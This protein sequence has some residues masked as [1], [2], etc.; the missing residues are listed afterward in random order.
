MR[1]LGKSDE[2]IQNESL[3]EEKSCRSNGSLRSYNPGRHKPCL[4]KRLDIIVTRHYSV[5][6][7]SNPAPIRREPKLNWCGTT[8]ESHVAASSYKVWVSRCL[9][10]GPPASYYHLQPEALALKALSPFQTGSIP[11]LYCQVIYSCQSLH[12]R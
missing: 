12:T 9:K 3:T 6:I 11:L 10:A 8:A 1:L 2:M 4:L 5:T 7:P